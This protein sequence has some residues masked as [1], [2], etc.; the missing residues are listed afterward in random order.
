VA[1]EAVDLLADPEHL[2]L[3]PDLPAADAAEQAG[4]GRRSLDLDL[5]APSPSPEHFIGDGVEHMTPPQVW[6]R[7][8]P[9]VEDM[10]YL[11]F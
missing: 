8:F 10:T 1:L 7:T 5:G 3:G 11:L 2:L 4:A 6:S 9:L